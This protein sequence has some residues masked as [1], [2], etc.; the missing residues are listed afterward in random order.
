MVAVKALP[1]NVTAYKRTP[2]FTVATVPAGLLRPGVR[3]F[4]EFYRR[5]P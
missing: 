1:E 3:F 4:V 2:E 5:Q